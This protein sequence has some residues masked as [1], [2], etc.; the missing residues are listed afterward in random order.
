[1]SEAL[2]NETNDFDDDDREVEND[3]AEKGR[4]ANIVSSTVEN[5]V[6]SWKFSNGEA[7]TADVKKLSPEAQFYHAC[8]SVRSAGRLSFQKENDPVRAADLLRDK[9]VRMMHGETGTHRAKSEPT[10]LTQALVNITG[11][12]PQYIEDVWYAA[13]FARPESGCTTRV[14]GGK[15]RVYGK[16]KA[17]SDLCLASNI[18][19]EMEKVVKERNAKNGKASGNKSF[20]VAGLV[21]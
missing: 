14:V 7:V 15:P 12:S 2:R 6:V 4:R 11:K 8:E 16:E 9:V 18:K 21:T 3:T 5:G 20:D 19:A 10:V 13:Y 17:L 1:M